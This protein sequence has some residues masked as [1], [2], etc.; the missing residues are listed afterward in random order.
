MDQD[1]I[2]ETLIRNV[3]TRL[4]GNKRIRRQLP[5]RGRIHIDRQL[6][7]LCLYRQPGERDDAGTERLI[8]GQA[9]YVIASGKPKY[10]KGLSLLMANVIRT[11]SP[12]FGGFL[13]VELW[14]PRGGGSGTQTDG[15]ADT[16]AFRILLHP[17]DS[18]RLSDTVETLRKA[19]ENVKVSRRIKTTTG[20]EVHYA[21]RI[22]PT[23]L[24]PLVS[25]SEARARGC[26]LI[27]IEVAPV[28]RNPESGD[29]FPLVLQT[30]RRSMT[31]ALQRAFFEFTRSSTTHRPPHYQA[32]GRRAV[33][34]AVFEVDQKLAEVA[35]A[36]D[37]LLQV[38][39][40]NF[41]S[42]WSEFKRRGFERAPRFYYRPLPVD[43]DLMKRK[44]Y[45]TPVEKV[46][47]PTL[48]ALFREKRRELDR[49]LSMLMER[50]TPHFFYGSLQLFGSVDESL[51]RLAREILETYPPRGREAGKN[52]H[53]TAV[54]IAEHA[55]IEI[56]SY[57]EAYAD[58]S[59]KV[60]V[61]D[62]ISSG[63]MV[64]FDTL[65]IGQ[66]TRI[67]S[68]RREAIL[69][70][71]I[72]THL[73][74]YFNG[75]AQPFKLLCLG[76]ADYQELQEGLAVLSEYLGGVL[77]PA[78][79][80]VLAARVIAVESL[81]QGASFVETFRALNRIYGFERSTAFGI[82]MRVYRGGGLTKDGVYLRGLVALLDYLRKGGE[83]EPLLIGKISADHISVVR[84]LQLRKVLSSP[85]LMPR[86]LQ[87]DRGKERLER[88]RTRGN[89]FEL[90]ERR[91]K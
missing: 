90:V 17:R 21:T 63:L 27:G 40:V 11:L 23:D 66:G 36:F 77:T 1:T 53:L 8:T 28:F 75:R 79:L 14:T 91:R 34:K 5:A 29:P 38:T 74:T 83:L 82:T 72:G 35:N 19:L 24:P 81:E 41:K 12:E 62:D 51:L 6:P 16:P 7:F 86:Y 88:V 68:F 67:P 37:F 10:R 45:N 25:F 2:T 73:L 61:R 59:A 50:N 80:R 49:Q 69:H 3:C 42:A 13:F 30:M 71:E 76:L 57:R 20:V 78:R 47:D 58:F 85:A 43:P 33:V 26:S 15:R 87:S 46:E 32:L 4:A 52:G 54:A 64:S 44:L 65:L 56:A 89:V 55:R 60:E 84:E 18:Q 39:P 9:S 22:S 48:A 31:R 70:H